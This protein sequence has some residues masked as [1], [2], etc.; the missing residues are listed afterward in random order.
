MADVLDQFGNALSI[1]KT[2]SRVPY[3]ALLQFHRKAQAATEAD[4]V[5]AEVV[6]EVVP[7]VDFLKVPDFEIAAQ[8]RNGL[9]LGTLH[10]TFAFDFNVA[11]TRH[12]TVQA[13]ALHANEFIVFHVLARNLHGVI[14]VAT[15]EV[16]GGQHAATVGGVHDPS[17]A[18]SFHRAAE[19]GMFFE[20][21]ANFFCVLLECRGVIHFELPCAGHA[22]G[23]ELLRAHHST[24][25]RAACD[26]FVR[27]DTRVQ[28]FVFAS[29][30]DH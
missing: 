25:A 15:L 18:E 7:F 11:P 2:H 16:A 17:G 10:P 30:P 9:I 26:T 23:L 19:H 22:D 29:R 28:D 24:D 1:A 27:H 13:A 6:G 12:G 14:K 8:Q 3:T 4:R 5:H 21:L 20:H